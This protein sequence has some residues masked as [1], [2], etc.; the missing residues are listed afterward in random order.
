MVIQPGRMARAGRD[1]RD[2]RDVDMVSAI[3]P[4]CKILLVEANFNNDSD[5]GTA[6]DAAVQAGAKYVSNSYG[7][8]EYPSETSSD[9]E[10]YDHPGDVITASAGDG[11]Y[12][13]SYPAASPDVVAVG[14][15]RLVAAADARGWSES[16]WGSASGGEGTG[17]GCSADEPK[18]SWQTDTDCTGRIDNDI[19][20]D[21]YPDTG[22]AVYDTYDAGGWLEVGGTSAS[23][24]M[25]AAV[26]ALAGAPPA[27]VAPAGLLYQHAQDL[28]DVS[29]GADGACGSN[30]LCTAG[31]GYDGPTGLGTPDGIGAFLS[32]PQGPS[33][34]A[35][36]AI[37]GTVQDGRTL[38]VT[39]G[40]WSP[41][42][43]LT[44]SYQ[45][46]TC[47]SSCTPISGATKRRSR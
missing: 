37:S 16:V 18:P 26:Y 35:A 44:F 43:G 19:S 40:T 4:H 22:V 12:G 20:A 28:Y 9:T 5:L 41:A 13:V 1:G 10:Y 31:V 45:W 33:S 14:G 27:S 25:V 39:R 42:K 30:S 8:T 29:S 11:G 32:A 2:G 24:P 36:P 15:T 17:S 23:S 3:C 21:A 46:E 47:S 6:V 38:T 34:T 7:G